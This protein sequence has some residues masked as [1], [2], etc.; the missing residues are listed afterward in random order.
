MMKNTQENYMDESVDEELTPDEE[1]EISGYQPEQVALIDREFLIQRDSEQA[2][3][4]DESENPLIR[5]AIAI[6][7]V[8][9][10]MGFAWM[11]WSIIFA[12]KPVV[13][14]PTPKP[15]PTIVSSGETDEA[16]RLKAELALRNQASRNV[17]QPQKQTLSSPQRIKPLTTPRATFVKAPAPRIIREKVPSPPR[18]IREKVPSP[19]RII[20]ERVPAPAQPKAVASV[21]PNVEKVDPFERWNQLATLGQQT[22]SVSRK[23]QEDSS[24]LQQAQALPNQS[25]F[26]SENN[27]TSNPT[28]NSSP[29]TFTNATN[30][31]DDKASTISTAAINSHNSQLDSNFEETQT[32]GEWG[33]LNRTPPNSQRETATFSTTRAQV[34]IGT[35]AKAKVIVPM[36]WASE[37]KNQGRF[38]VELQGDILS[39]DNRI[40]LPKG[41][42]L[43][44]EVDSVSKA[45]KLVKQ[46]VVAIIYTDSSG[47]V[48]QQTIPK[49]TILI[50]GDNNKPLVAKSISDKGQ[51]IAQ[52]D[53][54]VG[55]LGAAGRAGEIFN[56]LQSQSST[57]VNNG[58][59]NSQT[60]TTQARKPN[61][62][63]AAVE[64]F[65]KPMSQRLS[66][67]ADK[68]NSEILSRPDVAIVP[69][70]TKV[71][72]FF[73]SFL[74]FLVNII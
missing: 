9:G 31:V 23:L 21:A 69:T 54:L 64:G 26:N 46:S 28:D 5:G 59:F 73:N 29:I 12:N 56:S 14:A 57:V 43:I 60:I 71:S 18:I 49:D 47:R 52:Q 61:V 6:I 4:I 32:P 25:E 17:E 8:G 35:S 53:I 48:Q 70:D 34:Q 37:E 30:K 63:A 55:L 65:F 15:T 72:I 11:V 58:G 41:T 39:T 33:I 1:L 20:R 66:Q 45:N 51:A 40:A 16:A 38:A 68:A 2:E 42:I 74:K 22:T 24:P 27:T 50:R 67:R 10:V 44:T 36:I 19:P 62:L 7:L 13:K 3:P